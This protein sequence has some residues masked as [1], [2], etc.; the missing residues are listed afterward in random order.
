MIYTT[1]PVRE[2][3]IPL[4]LLVFAGAAPAQISATLVAVT[5][6]SLS[7]STSAGTM[8]NVLP[9]GFLGDGA[10][11]TI[12]DPSGFARASY[13][14]GFDT[15][16]WQVH[17]SVSQI[18]QVDAAGGS[19]SAGPIA[20]LLR[21]TSPVATF[22]AI[23]FAFLDHTIPGSPQPMASV[24]LGNDGIF[25]FQNGGLVLPTSMVPLGPQPLDILIVTHASLSQTGMVQA[26]LN[27]TLTPVNDLIV[28]QAA[29]GCGAPSSTLASFVD[30]GIDLN[31]NPAAH[32]TVV[33]FGLSTQPALLPPFG[34][35]PCL[36]IPSP[37]VL[38]LN[39]FQGSIHVPLPLAVRPVTFWAQG[40]GIAPSGLV[41]SDAYRIQAL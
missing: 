20:V 14:I 23:D 5:P 31:F 4:A 24:D 40:A 29:V 38:L 34:G 39:P 10:L 13:S 2:L 18:A 41:L 21:L 37:D 9:P 22:A 3:A 36:L 8:T 6:I 1:H 35:L 27:L 16:D 26:L 33:A 32:P 28:S 15:S 7:A 25:E 12:Q 30:R 11:L 19:A 17:C